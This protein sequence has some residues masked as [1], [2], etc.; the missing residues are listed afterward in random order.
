M[1]DKHSGLPHFENNKHNQSQSGF[2]LVELM[3]VISIIGILAM[4][5]STFL[6][7][8]TVNS[9]INKVENSIAN[10]SL[11]L[12]AQSDYIAGYTDSDPN[13]GYLTTFYEGQLILVGKEPDDINV[14]RPFVRQDG[15][16]FITREPDGSLGFWPFARFRI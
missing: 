8:D 10:R 3:V 13:S 1:N 15:T 5:A 9:S 2:T 14:V 11:N 4:N 16:T 7:R 12:K 6:G